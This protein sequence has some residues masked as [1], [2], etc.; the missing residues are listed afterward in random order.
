MAYHTPRPNQLVYF[1]N[2]FAEYFGF[3]N[4]LQ[5][6]RVNSFQTQAGRDQLRE[7]LVN[8]QV[9]VASPTVRFPENSFY[10]SFVDASVSTVYNALLQSTDTRNRVIEVENS[11]SVSTTEQI[12]AV[13]RTDD[14]STAIHNNLDQLLNLLAAGT[15]VLDRQ[16]FESTSGLTW[17]AQGALR[18]TT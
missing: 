17:T 15:G 11:S 1:T 4:S 14:A 16:S 8:S 9:S 6:A 12:N 10:V 7:V 13:R 2:A 5:K 3:V 18:A